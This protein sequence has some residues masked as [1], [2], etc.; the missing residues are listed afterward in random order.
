[1]SACGRSGGH[2]ET[3]ESVAEKLARLSPDALAS[4]GPHHCESVL[5]LN[6]EGDRGAKVIQERYELQWDNWDQ[7]RYRVEKNGRKVMDLTIWKGQA[8]QRQGDGRLKTRKN[9]HEMHYYL[10]QTWNQWEAAVKPFSSVLRYDYRQTEIVEGRPVHRYDLALES[11]VDPLPGRKGR[12]RQ[13]IVYD[14]ING[15]IWIDDATGLPLK[16]VMDAGYR[17]VR[18]SRRP[19][20][21]GEEIRFRLEFRLRRYDFGRQ[22]VTESPGQLA[23]P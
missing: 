19:G 3:S 14:S 12:S 10:R 1:M 7:Y 6:S 9:T 20:H 8:Y 11:V 2:R 23:R 5:L 17:H 13:S 21:P 18:F 22:Q 15:S 4:L 16:A